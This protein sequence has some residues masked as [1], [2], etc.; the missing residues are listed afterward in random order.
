MI[1]SL[2]NNLNYLSILILMI[3]ESSAI[4]FPSEVVVPPAAYHAAGGYL[5]VFL[6]WVFATIGADIG[7]TANYV[8]G[9]YLG[10][11]VIYRFANSRFGRLCMLSQ[12]KVEQSEKYFNDHG[13][14]ATITGR[15][16]P[17]IRQLISI[18]AGL[19][20]MTFWKFILYTTI[21]AGAWNAVL[22]TM[23]YCLFSVVP[24][25]QL[26]DK[27]LE[28]EEYIKVGIAILLMLAL[29]YAFIRWYLRRRKRKN[30]EN[31][32]FKD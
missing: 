20:K 6:V 1:T 31:L 24:E 14:V 23:G 15:L 10:R 28:Y 25:D 32:D 2:L 11:P 3:I 13:A 17:G 29:G 4:P 30:L 27:V 9:Y 16:I 22:A 5:N 8:A 18:P 26:N 7:A 19:A 12:E 21:G